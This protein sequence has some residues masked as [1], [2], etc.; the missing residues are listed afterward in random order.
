MW[1]STPSDEHQGSPD[2][3]WSPDAAQVNQQKAHY[4]SFLS[5]IGALSVKHSNIVNMHGFFKHDSS[6]TWV[7]E[8]EYLGNVNLTEWLLQSNRTLDDV[9]RLME[10][11]FQ[12]V[13][14]LHAKGITHSDLQPDNI[15]VISANHPILCDFGNS[16]VDNLHPHPPSWTTGDEVDSFSMGFSAPEVR[17]RQGDHISP[18]LIPARDIFSLGVLLYFAL[19]CVS[20]EGITPPPHVSPVFSLSNDGDGALCQMVLSPPL[21]PIVRILCYQSRM[22]HTITGADFSSSGQGSRPTDREVLRQRAVSALPVLAG[23]E[24]L[25]DHSVC[26]KDSSRSTELELLISR[27]LNA[28]PRERPTAGELCTDPFFSSVRTGLSSSRASRMVC[29]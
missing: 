27:M 1:C 22:L 21:N 3:L 11:L 12:V 29:L 23:H 15:M 4:Q 5:E 18:E 24:V 16:V 28:D 8:L 19:S 20:S 17:T 14:Y 26:G 7:I 25:W 10:R 9:Y 6:D 2:G 13:Q